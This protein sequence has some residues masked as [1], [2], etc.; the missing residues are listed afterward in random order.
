MKQTDRVSSDMKYLRCDG[1]ES[2]SKSDAN[3]IQRLSVSRKHE[4]VQSLVQME[5]ENGRTG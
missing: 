3:M 1:R 4:L 2:R 5:A